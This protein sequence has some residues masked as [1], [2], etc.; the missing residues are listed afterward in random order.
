M[1]RVLRPTTL[2]THLQAERTDADRQPCYSVGRC[3][4]GAWPAGR[5]GVYARARV[6]REGS[7]PTHTLTS[8]YRPEH[9]EGTRI[10]DPTAGPAGRSGGSASCTTPDTRLTSAGD[11][12]RACPTA[13]E[14]QLLQLAPGEWVVELHRTTYTADDTVVEFAIGTHAATRFAWTYDFKVPDS[15]KAEEESK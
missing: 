2:R 9:V 7:Q 11:T 6:V 14:V 3:R 13:D 12:V 10:V 1:R 4:S 5:R 8:Y 15:A